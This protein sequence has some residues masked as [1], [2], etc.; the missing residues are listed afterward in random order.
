MHVL[1]ESWTVNFYVVDVVLS[2]EVFF[3]IKQIL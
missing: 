2:G 3:S 1:F